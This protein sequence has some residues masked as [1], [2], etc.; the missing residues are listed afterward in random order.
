MLQGTRQ[1][2]WDEK[3]YRTVGLLV[4]E[5]LLTNGR[6]KIVSKKKFITALEDNRLNKKRRVADCDTL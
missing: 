2:V 1:Q 4:R 3:A 6:G 5:D